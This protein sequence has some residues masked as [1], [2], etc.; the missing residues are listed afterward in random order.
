M[1]VKV[2]PAFDGHV[3]TN[4]YFAY[5]ESVEEWESITTIEQKCRGPHL[6]NRLVG[7]A[8]RLKPLFDMELLKDPEKGVSYFLSVLRPHFIKDNEHVFLWRFFKFL[9]KKR[10]NADITMWIP[11]FVIEQ[12]RLTDSW[13]DLAPILVDHT[14]INYRATM[15]QEHQRRTVVMQQDFNALQQEFNMKTN[16]IRFSIVMKTETLWRLHGIHR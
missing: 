6:R 8:T 10:G 5:E 16:R 7:E 11:S 13:M 12:K 4:G 15:I 2:P 1:T 9:N 14:D 3:Q